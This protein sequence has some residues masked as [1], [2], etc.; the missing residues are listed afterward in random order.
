MLQIETERDIERLRQ[1]A[2]LQEAEI[3]RLLARLAELTRQLA[4]ARGD[5]VVRALQLELTAINEQLAARPYSAWARQFKSE[6]S[7]R[8]PR[9][10][11]AFGSNTSGR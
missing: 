4:E 2:L 9:Y 5:D 11:Q 6:L 8:G 10:L 7:T 1:V 3:N